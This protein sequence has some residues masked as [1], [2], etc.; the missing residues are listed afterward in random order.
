VRFSAAAL[1]LMPVSLAPLIVRQEQ[2]APRRYEQQSMAWLEIK[3]GLTGPDAEKF[4][5]ALMGATLP[6]GMGSIGPNGALHAFEGI[7]VSSTPDQHPNKFLIAMPGNK[8][9][10]LTLK[11][12]GSLAK[13][14]P[15][16]T[17]ISFA[18]DVEAF[19]REPFMLTLEVR[20]VNRVV[21]SDDP[22]NSK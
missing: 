6:V 20:T 17:L 12:K 1:V 21:R 16:G 18:G 4:L 8:T 19:T 13:P 3:K 9:P 15:A 5:E 10:E 11:M 14:L 2:Q 7:L 22:R